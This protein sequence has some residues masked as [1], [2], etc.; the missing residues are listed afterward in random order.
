MGSG[1]MIG[2]DETA[3][4]VNVAKFF[5]AFTQDESCGKCTPCREGTK[6]M[7]EI[8]TRITEGRGEEGDVE[9]LLR[10]AET[11]KMTSLCG[12]GQAAPNP[13]ISTIKHFRAEYD[14]HIREKRCPTGQCKQLVTYSIDPEKCVGCTACARV[15]P[16]SC[17]AGEKKKRHVIDQQA[18]ITCGS[19]FEVCKFDAVKRS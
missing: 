14:A 7:L 15:C 5:L 4:M 10:L 19:C 6:R 3:C 1:G 12:L 13:V 17:I 9:K 11:V 18:C 16:V 2:M 8:L